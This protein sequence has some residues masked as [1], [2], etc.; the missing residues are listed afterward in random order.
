M[1]K[2]HSQLLATFCKG[3]QW[4]GGGGVRWRRA[5]KYV[6]KNGM[7]KVNMATK[8][9]MRKRRRCGGVEQRQGLQRDTQPE[10]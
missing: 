7:P 4:C 3:R 6:P 8:C 2:K 9:A 10:P 5:T 1:A